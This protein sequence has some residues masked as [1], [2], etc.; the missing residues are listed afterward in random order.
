MKMTA[1]LEVGLNVRDL[2][3]MREFYE[4]VLEL[5][6]VNEIQVSA[7]KARQAALNEQGYT[8]VRLQT[9][10]GERLK[11]LASASPPAPV[12]VPPFILDRPGSAY[13]TF[14][15][16]DIRAACGRV[17]AAG[18]HFMTGPEPVEVRPGTWL[19]FFKD[20]EGHVVELVQYDDI[21]AYRPDLQGSGQPA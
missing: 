12:V 11:L 21:G 13:V 14:I 6:F 16:D 15:I 8:V 17:R 7:A 2:K 4:T 10:N 3:K 20:P 1:P 19:A 18:A 5:S 9:S